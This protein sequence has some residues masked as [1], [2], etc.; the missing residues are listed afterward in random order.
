MADIEP[1][2]SLDIEAAT[3]ARIAASPESPW[4]QLIGYWR[5][6][7]ARLGPVPARGDIDPVEIGG[8][9]L[10]NLFLVDI[11]PGAGPGEGKRYRFRLVGERIAA[12]ET[13][14][15]GHYL[16]DIAHTP[17][18]D[19]I[20]RHYADAQAGRIRL[21]ETT[22]KWES[23]DKD[24]VHYRSVVLPLAASDDP[25]RIGHLIGCAVYDDEK[26]FG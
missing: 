8:Q 2:L 13:V 12:R 4:A 25:G 24:H 20:E 17:D 15:P 10:G 21:R 26:W 5:R 18:I 22:L 9:L 19:G 23:P 3:A 7:A 14:R 11:E 6:L 1:F 16:T